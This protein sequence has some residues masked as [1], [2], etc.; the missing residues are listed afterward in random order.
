M[1]RDAGYVAIL[2][3]QWDEYLNVGMPK[4]DALRKKSVT[5]RDMV[6][7]RTELRKEFI[8]RDQALGMQ[9]YGKPV[10]DIEAAL[11]FWYGADYYRKPITAEANNLYR[12][13]YLR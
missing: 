9:K 11:V 12:R 10:S 5:I 1:P 6:K 3:K 2:Q 8:K 7:R 4:K 13:L